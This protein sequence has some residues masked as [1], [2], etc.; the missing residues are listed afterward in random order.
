LRSRS[1]VRAER[2]RS[3]SS[4]PLLINP[5]TAM[6]VRRGVCHREPCAATCGAA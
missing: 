3:K 1:S 2:C 5:A 6:P 4:H